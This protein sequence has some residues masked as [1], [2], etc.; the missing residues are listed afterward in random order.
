MLQRGVPARSVHGLLQGRG[1][2]H[3]RLIID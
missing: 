1:V 3:L 2:S